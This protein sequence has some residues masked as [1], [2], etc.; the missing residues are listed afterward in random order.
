MNKENMFKLIKELPFDKKVVVYKE[1]NVELFLLRPSKVKKRFQDYDKKKN[2]Q[3]WLNDSYREFIPNHLRVFID[4]NLRIRSRPDL[5]KRLLLAFDNI[6]YG[7]D[8]EEELKELSKEDFEHFLNP[9]IAIGYC[10]QIFVIEQ[11]WAYNKVSKYEPPS[12]FFQG[13]IREFIDNPKEIDNLCM[14]VCNRQS[15]LTNYT[16]KE[17]KKHKNFERDLKVLWYI[18]KDGKTHN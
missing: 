7:K 10:A 3:L 1:G 17:N 11:E 13:W 14:S 6:Y 12:L 9:L 18:E 5:K 2:L 15:P 16:N 4:L 8:P